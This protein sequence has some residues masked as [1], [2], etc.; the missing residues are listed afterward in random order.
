MVNVDSMYSARV[1]ERAWGRGYQLVGDVTSVSPVPSACIT[2]NTGMAVV[3][4]A[5]LAVAAVG[6]SCGHVFA[7]LR[8]QEDGTHPRS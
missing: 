8:I 7:G 6:G 4:A 2:G 5:V 1:N 3:P